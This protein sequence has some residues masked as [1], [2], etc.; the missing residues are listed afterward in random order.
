MGKPERMEAA[1]AKQTRVE[2]KTPMGKPKVDVSGKEVQTAIT[3]QIKA[4]MGA[5]GWREADLAKAA[6]MP[7]S[8]LNR[9]LSG[10][11]DVPLPIFAELCLALGISITE[12]LQRAQRRHDETP[13]TIV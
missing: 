7:S 6:G 1:A 4:E 8:S 11:R 12:L 2:R 5:K 3:I 10:V 9:Y 13:G